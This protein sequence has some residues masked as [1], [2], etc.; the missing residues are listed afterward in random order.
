MLA[1]GNGTP[2]QCVRN[3]LSIIQ[4]EAPY[5][6]CKGVDADLTE[7]PSTLAGMV[8]AEVVQVLEEY[9]PRIDEDEIM[10]TVEDVLSGKFFLKAEITTEE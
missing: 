8:A 7:Q 5:E 10:L 9:E 4:G 6:R 1:S 3:L 2:Q